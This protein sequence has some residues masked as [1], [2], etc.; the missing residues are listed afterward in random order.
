MTDGWASVFCSVKDCGKVAER[1]G[2]CG[3]HYQRMYLYGRT[4]KVQ[5]IIK[6]NCIVEGCDRPIKGHGY[7]PSH[8]Q[9]WKKHGKAE[10]LKREKRSHP[11]Y[12]LWFERKH[13]DLLCEEWLDFTNFVKGISPKPEGNYILVRVTSDLYGPTN[14]KWMEHLKRKDGENKKDWH[15]RKWAARQA[16]NPGM[17]RA[18]NYKRF[19]DFTVE[20]YEEMVSNQNGLCAIC[21]KPET[22]VDAK[23]GTLKRLA[24][25]HD[26]STGKVREL[27]C[28][29]CNS[30]LGRVDDNIELLYKMIAYL[31]KHKEPSNV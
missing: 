13:A 23:A 22:S 31:V 16:A 24:I 4:E 2:Y 19:Y 30:T 14:F 8:Y 10:K 25:D 9:L 11:F 26:H 6:G 5:G 17:E 7:C 18:R 20:K 27:L 12:H 15:A 21:G 1:K 28:W 29:I 3:A